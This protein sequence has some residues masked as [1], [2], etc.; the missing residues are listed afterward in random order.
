MVFLCIKRPKTGKKKTF[1]RK[2][3]SSLRKKRKQR[4]HGK[5]GREL[6]VQFRVLGAAQHGVSPFYDGCV[7]IRII[8]S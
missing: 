3:K 6:L 5:T 7:F 1:P 8:L 2:G 4:S